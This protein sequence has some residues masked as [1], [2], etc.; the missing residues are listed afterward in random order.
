MWNG[1]KQFIFGESQESTPPQRVPTHRTVA[2]PTNEV[3]NPQPASS[4]LAVPSP[5]AFPTTQQA[6]RA[7]QMPQ[8]SQAQEDAEDEELAAVMLASREEHRNNTDQQHRM[9]LQS[10]CQKLQLQAQVISDLMSHYDEY[11]NECFGSKATFLSIDFEALCEAFDT[12]DEAVQLNIILYYHEELVGQ[13]DSFVNQF[14]LFL[15]LR[16]D[17]LSALLDKNHEYMQ[18]AQKQQAQHEEARGDKIDKPSQADEE[19][20]ELAQAIA[21]SNQTFNE[22]ATVAVQSVKE[23]ETSVPIQG[24]TVEEQKIVLGAQEIRRLRCLGIDLRSTLAKDD[25]AITLIQEHCHWSESLALQEQRKSLDAQ[26]KLVAAFKKE[27]KENHTLE[28]LKAFIS[29][30]QEKAPTA[31]TTAFDKQRNETKSKTP[32]T[33]EAQGQAPTNEGATP[34]QGKS[35]RT[36]GEKR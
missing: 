4:G 14:N 32:E 12:L 35:R 6:P 5:V 15:N 33:N 27:P 1:L 9:R 8:Q 7:V 17:P 2:N 19:D 30:Y 21:L 25:G 24:P 28:G 31:L 23:E 3:P 34:K 26:E 10:F 36:S 16:G 22:P 18:S 20:D 29:T 11:L 13:A